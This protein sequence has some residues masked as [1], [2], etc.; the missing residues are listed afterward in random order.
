MYRIKRG[1]WGVALLFLIYG[2]GDNDSYR[3]EV[4]GPAGGYAGA[5]AFVPGMFTGNQTFYAYDEEDQQWRGIA[6]SPDSSIRYES[7]EGIETTSTYA[8]KEGKLYVTDANRDPVISLDSATETL[9]RVTKVESDGRRWQDTWYL[10]LQF[11]P[12]MLQGKCYMSTFSNRGE[13]VQEK[14]C[15]SETML[16]T[17]TSDGTLKHSYPYLLTNHTISVDRDADRFTLHLMDIEKENILRVWYVSPTENYANHALWV[18]I[19]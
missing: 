2:C 4:N 17:Y 1:L 9:F 10:E 13:A 19:Q 11:K 7:V 3:K 5:T 15:F 12:E 18:P 6:F 16:S 14:V 8:V